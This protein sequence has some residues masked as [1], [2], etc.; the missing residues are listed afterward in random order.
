[1]IV[2]Y[3]PKCSKCREAKDLLENAGCEFTLREYLKEPPTQKELR[4]LIKKLGCKPFDLVRTK[5]LLYK[6]EFDGK[7]MTSA[8]WIKAL[9]DNPILIERPIVIA[10]DKALVGRPPSLVLDLTKRHQKIKK[11]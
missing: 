3:N 10:G 5:E 4:D 7:K 11:K 6:E 8:Q 2:Y 1:M 9:A